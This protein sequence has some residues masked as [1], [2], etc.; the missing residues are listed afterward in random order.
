[1]DATPADH[2][3]RAM[4][5][6]N[7]GN[8][9][10]VRFGRTG[11]LADLET[12]IEAEQAAVDAIPA[13]HANRAT[14]LSNLGGA[15]QTRF[16]YTGVLA[17]L[18]AAIEAGRAAAEATPADHP[19]RAIY[20]S[21][22]GNALR[23]RFG[24]TGAQADRQ[25][26]LSAFVQVTKMDSAVPSLRV[27]TGRAA[28]ALAA[29]S[30]PGLAASL[31]D[32]AVRLLPE[33]TPRQLARSDQQH[34]IG[35]FTGLAG[36]A[37]AL[38]L[39]DP[40][41]ADR[42]RPRRA[43]QLLETG[44]AVLLSQV[45]ETRSGLTDLRQHHPELAA[46][47]A[48]LR[49]LLDQTPGILG[50]VT[51]PASD[52]GTALW[53]ARAAEDRR[54]LADELATTLTRIR[55]LDGFA[56][57]GLPPA[58]SELL[59]QAGPGPVV[60]F[61]ISSYRSDALLLTSEDVTSLEL[62]GLTIRAVIDHDQLLPPG[63]GHCN[64]PGQGPAG[65]QSRAGEN[66]RRSWNGSGTPPPNRSCDA[67]GYHERARAG[68]R[69][70]HG[71]GG[72]PAALLGLLPL[73]AAGYHTD[74]PGSQ[75]RRTVMDRVVSSYTPTIRALRYA[76]QHTPRARCRRRW[77]SSS[78]CPP[79]RASPAGLPNVPAEV[80]MLRQP[81]ARGRAAHRTRTRGR[82]TGHCL[83]AY[84]DQ[85][86]RPGPPAQLPDRPLRLPWR[87][88]IRPTRPAAC[89]CS[90]TTRAIPLTVASLGPV[91]LGSGTAC[92][93][94]GLPDRLHQQHRTDRR[95]H[96]PHLGVPARR[97]PARHRHLVGNP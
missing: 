71:C 72:H 37:A 46:R 65:P 52:P 53:S 51:E 31:L 97:F 86:E 36:D 18:D 75:G 73:H 7:L 9:L 94:V 3:D 33:V 28:A 44:R 30:E 93:P 42:E 2:P 58:T 70:G 74:P 80:A 13:D 38:A 81:P 21:T 24:Q 57:F 16:G 77:R 45:L 6:S 66:P 85:G 92:L 40:D 10:L 59:A 95:G 84:A 61:N 41:T 48:E 1:M 67:L 34:A 89:C 90:T 15:L 25:A 14:Y 22:L 26:A 69:C 11:A 35:E 4:Y 27:M 62:P 87:Q 19:N 49:D 76:R 79:H 63:P 39:A 8:A 17:D 96:P 64:R 12:G 54:R 88:P 47:F 43:L 82:R 50:P 55:A 5:L 60:S 20:L 32:R 78:R 29:R 91:N 83:G 56:S 68:R 23:T